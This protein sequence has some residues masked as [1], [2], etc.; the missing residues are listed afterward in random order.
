MGGLSFSLFLPATN[1]HECCTLHL[2]GRLLNLICNILPS[3]FCAERAVWFLY[4]LP[5]FVT[6]WES[7]HVGNR[8][9]RTPLHT[10]FLIILPSD[11]MAFAIFLLTTSK[12][13]SGQPAFLSIP[14]AEWRPDS[15]L[16]Q[17]GSVNGQLNKP[18]LCHAEQF[19]MDQGQNWEAASL[20][21]VKAFQTWPSTK[22]SF[23]ARYHNIGSWNELNKLCLLARKAQGCFCIHH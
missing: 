11:L 22:V 15:P 20:V 5:V 16:M 13:K 17:A 1:W 9:R 2:L 18:L 12:T 3:F 19:Q 6:M 10:L 23:R 8:R 21:P 7:M 4:L 14:L